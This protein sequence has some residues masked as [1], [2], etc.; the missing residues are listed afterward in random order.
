MKP[1]WRNQ[2]I[3][4]LVLVLLAIPVHFLDEALNR[5]GG[6]GWI[7]LDFRGVIFWTYVAVVAIHIILSTLTARFFPQFGA[8]PRHLVIFPVSL[9][10]FA[11]GFYAWVLLSDM[12]QTRQLRALE[13]KRAPLADVIELKE[14]W[15][16][17]D[18]D[19]PT[20]IR[21]NVVV[22]SG[23]R[24]GG[25]IQG[26]ENHPGGNWNMVFISDNEPS[27]Q[28]RVKKD[29]DFIHH[30]TLKILEPGR[31][32][33]VSI[34]LWLF[35]PEIAPD[36]REIAKTYITSPVDRDAGGNFFAPLPPPTR[37]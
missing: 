33:N 16:Y 35:E 37:K 29:D 23:G 14:W 4:C 17:P 22:H 32:T 26:K 8:V 25:H 5:G 10:L 1:I 18:S 34:T 28:R 12:A 6:G 3:V 36:E 27:S 7:T 15:Y 30:F 2:L 21:V 13:A 20:E 9:L 31:A 19:A 24:F 11:G